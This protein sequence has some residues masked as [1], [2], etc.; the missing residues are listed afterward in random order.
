MYFFHTFIPRSVFKLASL[1]H[2]FIITLLMSKPSILWSFICISSVGVSCFFLTSPLT[3]L[4]LLLSLCSRYWLSFI[5]SLSFSLSG[6]F[7]C[8]ST[9]V[10]A[11]A[12]LHKVTVPLPWRCIALAGGTLTRGVGA[13]AQRGSQPRSPPRPAPEPWEPRVTGGRGGRGCPCPGSWK[14]ARLAPAA[15]LRP[16]FRGSAAGVN[17]KETKVSS[18]AN[19]QISCLIWRKVI[20]WLRWSFMYLSSKKSLKS[21]M[22]E[23]NS[24]A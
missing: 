8:Y 12:F 22:R 7:V 10:P 19:S 2:L 13:H 5:C 6:Y 3:W 23:E 15:R 18:K 1:S 4:P 9:T 24:T 20:S 17:G 21:D 11:A 14:L 16:S